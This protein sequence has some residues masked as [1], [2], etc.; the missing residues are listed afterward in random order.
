MR[1]NPS[2]PIVALLVL[3]SAAAAQNASFRGLRDL[4][5]GEFRSDAYAVSPD[6]RF[7]VGTSTTESTTQEGFLW[8]AD[9]GMMPLGFLL[10]GTTS[11]ATGV[12]A[13]GTVVTGYSYG[14][15]SYR[16][17][18]WTA[19]TGMQVLEPGAEVAFAWDISADGQFIVG[20]FGSS[21]TFGGGSGRSR[22]TSADSLRIRPTTNCVPPHRPSRCSRSR[23]S[24][25]SASLA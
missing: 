10:G 6:G 5:G 18:R 3:S 16:P 20:G 24:A 12:S 17:F 21:T 2:A 1:C 23:R 14:A 25:A 13:G 4:P 22:A 8:S 19:A 11:V 15:S 7:V 9:T